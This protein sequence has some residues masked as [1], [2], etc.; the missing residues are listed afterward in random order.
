[1][2]IATARPTIP[3]RAIAALTAFALAAAL[4][5]T[6]ASPAHAQ[7]SINL[8]PIANAG[9]DQTFPVGLGLTKTLDGS[10]SRDIELGSLTY[11]WEVLTPSYSG[12][13]I[14]PTGNPAGKTATFPTPTRADINQFG[15]SITFR[16]TVTDPQGLF[17]SDTVTYTFEQP[18]TLSTTV[19]AFLPNP[20]ATDTD[21]DGT[22]EDEERY[23]IDAVLGRPG[24][25][26]NSAIE[27]DI[28]EGARLTLGSSVTYGSSPADPSKLR[29][30]WRKLSAVPNRSDF[31][32]PVGQA[33][34]AGFSIILPS[35]LQ[36]DRV[37]I[38][39]YTLRVTTAS[40]LQS[41]VTV[42][43]NVVDQQSAPEVTLALANNQPAQDANALDPDAA[44]Q[45]Y[46]VGP[47]A[48]VEVVA[49]ATDSDATQQ[50]NLVHVWSGSNVAPLAT[51]PDRG[52]VSRAT[53][54]APAD[55]PQGGVFTVGVAVTDSTDRSGR[56]QIAFVV[57]KNKPPT[58]TA[59]DDFVAEDG[60]RGGTD[61][62]GLVE[63]TG[64][65]NDPDGDDLSYRWTQVDQN[66]DS[67]DK[68]TVEL[69]NADTATASFVP[70]QLAI[71][72]RRSFHFSFTVVDRW[73][74]GG[75]DIVTVHL[76]GRNERPIADAGTDQIVQSGADVQLDG[77]ASTDPD[78]G[79]RVK[80]S[81]AYTGFATTPSLTER[82]L[83]LFARKTLAGF[84][85]SGD[86]FDDYSR[87]NPLGNSSG[88]GRAFFTAPE[89]A[90]YTSLHLTFEL[91]VTDL[92]RARDTDTVTIVV[93]GTF[94]SGAISGPDFCTNL[95]LG[96]PRTYAFDSD[97]DG[98]A[99]VC[100][101]PYTRR[102]AVARQNALASLT[103]VEFSRFRNQ[104][105]AACGRLTGDFGDSASDLDADV[106]ATRQISQP[107]PPPDPAQS[108]LL[109]SGVIG[110]P[111]FCTNL[112][113]G[114]ARTYAFDSDRDGVADVC[115][116]P[117]TRREA[118]AR[119]NALETFTTPRTA[120]N[121]ALALAC[122]E[123][124]ASDFGDSP[125]DLATDVCA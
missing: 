67:L 92:Y 1:M 108:A 93:T 121:T 23:T 42:R 18:P 25:E 106:C 30:Y 33:N 81:W 107:P 26:G 123:L 4:L 13:V 116:L 49:T 44:T 51:N 105:L 22:I 66:G 40:G 37:A 5:T 89:L 101:L 69:L 87:L 72:G 68:P 7:D 85:P 98:V 43:I 99:D 115:S 95:S 65:G 109:Y 57:A 31:N 120:Y 118:V 114:G 35:D 9:P 112:S 34:T 110:G 88:I 19:S 3:K 119:Q 16:L 90:G 76:F 125:V 46:V 96:G 20:D 71:D 111:D 39:H 52:A 2:L 59:P 55:T 60:P 91:T 41:E 97:R 17:G 84:V 80:W 124:A 75:T 50:G 6:A 53:F 73:G 54:T 74:V 45:R 32:V 56:D 58:A 103:Q 12:L 100:S 63:L 11:R 10:R 48:T 64:T 77:T 122:R 36:D 86:D 15:D 78:P 82:P 102:E 29:Y 70:P 79:D 94:F 38:V 27:W 117:T 113:L 8:A 28:K 14:T 104:V 21:G 83:T 62:K 24:Q 47:G 61:N